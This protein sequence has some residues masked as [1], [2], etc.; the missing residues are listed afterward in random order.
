MTTL[1]KES[2]LDVRAP[3]WR[4]AE[5][6]CAA[7]Q[8]DSRIAV[9]EQKIVALEMLIESNETERNEAIAAA[10]ER[11]RKQAE[12]NFAR[13]EASRLKALEQA[14]TAAATETSQRLD[15]LDAL[16]L[17]LAQGALASVFERAGDFDEL[18]IRAIGRELADLKQESVLHVRV[19]ASDFADEE[20]LGALVRRIGAAIRIECD[21]QLDAGAC[22]IALRLGEIELSLPEYWRALRAKLLSFAEPR[23]CS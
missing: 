9:L 8:T 15:D 5:Q 2:A 19:S 18:L 21:D 7:S 6:T 3:E 10:I 4:P 16:S 17:A 11:G 12:A 1:F 23:A 14:L 22:R 13:D 20:A